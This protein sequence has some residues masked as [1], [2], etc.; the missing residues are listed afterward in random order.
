M[1]VMTEG[2]F[3]LDADFRARPL[4]FF[5][6]EALRVVLGLEVFADL[7]AGTIVGNAIEFPSGGKKIDITG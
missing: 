2:A 5:R 7:R 1:R 6:T 3:F 4:V